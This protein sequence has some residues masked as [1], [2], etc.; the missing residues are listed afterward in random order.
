MQAA[1][2]IA[3]HLGPEWTAIER[4][5]RLGAPAAT[6]AGPDSMRLSLS[7]VDQRWR[8]DG[9]LGDRWSDVPDGEKDTHVI[10]ASE[11]KSAQRLAG[12][13]RRRL[14]PDYQRVLALAIERKRQH[15]ERTALAHQQADR[16]SMLLGGHRY[17]KGLSS[18]FGDPYQRGG[19]F[20]VH[21]TYVQ[22]EIRMP[23]GEADA[24]AMAVARVLGQANAA[25]DE[26][27]AQAEA[28]LS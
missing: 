26:T 2:E 20:R 19:E 21:G 5:S 17:N 23:K 4:P 12:E 14:L 28:E 15:D 11:A 7:L 18:K 22:F 8:I 10:T 24:L 16:L 9:E 6:L 27:A 25:S 3:T 13:I 1:Q